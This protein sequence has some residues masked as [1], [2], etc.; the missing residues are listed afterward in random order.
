MDCNEIINA[1]KAAEAE[2]RICFIEMLQEH[3]GA[4]LAQLLSEERQK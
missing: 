4:N 3:Y 2:E 1:W